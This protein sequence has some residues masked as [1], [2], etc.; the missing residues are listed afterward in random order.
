MSPYLFLFVFGYF[1]SKGHGWKQNEPSLGDVCSLWHGVTD[2]L[3]GHSNTN[4]NGRS[5]GEKR[6]EKLWSKQWKKKKEGK[7][8]KGKKEM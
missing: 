2:F 1:V 4:V 5:G 8:K 6:W 7:E 3:L